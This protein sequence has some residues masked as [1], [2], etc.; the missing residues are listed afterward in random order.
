MPAQWV[1]DG[2]QTCAVGEQTC[3][4]G[5]AT[6]RDGCAERRQL[7]KICLE[8]GGGETEIDGCLTTISTKKL[9]NRLKKGV[10]GVDDIRYTISWVMIL[11]N[12]ACAPYLSEGERQ[13]EEVEDTEPP[14]SF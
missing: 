8:R 3:A 13:G 2:E 5:E 10:V 6:V 14:Y 12:A 4:V 9:A 7:T 1:R 11:L